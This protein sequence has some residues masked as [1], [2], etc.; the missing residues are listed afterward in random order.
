MHRHPG[1][2]P[3]YREEQHQ[4]GGGPRRLRFLG[5]RPRL[6]RQLYPD[7][8]LPSGFP[9]PPRACCPCCAACAALSVWL[10]GWPPYTSSIQLQNAALQSAVRPPACPSR[11]HQGRLARRWQ[12]PQEGVSRRQRDR[13]PPWP[14]RAAECL[15]SSNPAEMSSLNLLLN[16]L[17]HSQFFPCIV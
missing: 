1:L 15:P 9:L 4:P 17:F 8:S 10:R 7:A 3:S 6:Q 2:R 14:L 12:Q 11:L 5:C 13:W 16:L